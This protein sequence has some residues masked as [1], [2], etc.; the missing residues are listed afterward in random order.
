MKKTQI[1]GIGILSMIIIGCGSNM[2][3]SGPKLDG[4]KPE[5]IL[6]MEPDWYKNTQSDEGFIVGKGEGTSPS[7]TGARKIAV[8]NLLTDL[9]QKTK[10]IT[11]GRNEDFFKQTGTDYNSTVRQQFE[12]TQTAIWNSMLEGYEE[13][14]SATLPEKSVNDQ[15]KSVTIYRTYITGRLNR[16]NADQRLLEKIKMEQELLTAVQATEAYDKLQKDLEKY[17]KKFGM[18]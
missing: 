16:F 17:R 9:S 14:N 2:P 15:G 7:K 8:N 11:E 6:E 5:K 10:V 13:V 4:V 3:K 18:E 1:I 12:Q